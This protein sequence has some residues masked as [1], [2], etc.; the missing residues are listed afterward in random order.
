MVTGWL[1]SQE[2]HH[3]HH[4]CQ[5]QVR[6]LPYDPFVFQILE[7]DVL[8]CRTLIRMIGQTWL[9]PIWNL[10]PPPGG[11]AAPYRLLKAPMNVGAFFFNNPI[12]I[13]FFSK[14][15]CVGFIQP[16]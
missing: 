4:G 3:H 16:A 7:V 1:S 6:L 12:A 8:F 15:R 2:H 5:P 10:D 14:W 9:V 11:T 13:N